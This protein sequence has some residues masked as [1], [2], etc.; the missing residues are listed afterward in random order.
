MQDTTGPALV[1]DRRRGSVAALRRLTVPL[2][3]LLWCV[4]SASYAPLL[5]RGGDAASLAIAG[6]LIAEGHADALYTQTPDMLAVDDPAWIAAAAPLGYDWRLYPYLYPPLV[7]AIAAPAS[8]LDFV[9]FKAGLLTLTLAALAGAILLSARAW[10]PRLLAPTPLLILLAAISASWPMT[11]QLIALNLQPLVLLAIVIAICAAQSDRPALAGAALALAGAVKLTPAV[12]VLYWLATRRFACAAWFLIASAALILLGLA[13]AGAPAHLAW[14]GRMQE[15][16]Q[17]IVPTAHNRSLAS[18]F[19]GLV[20]G[21]ETELQGLPI[22]PM[23]A[24]V[25]VALIIMTLAGAAF[26]LIGAQRSRRHSAAD[27]AGQT[28]LLLVAMLGTPL[29]WSHYFLVLAVAAMV[30]IGLVGVTSRT[31]AVLAGVAIVLSQ[32]VALAWAESAGP[33][34]E[35]LV[36]VLFLVLLL[37]ARRRYCQA[38]ATG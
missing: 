9:L 36:A 13:L 26:C 20:H 12:L 21:F 19:Y 16:A 5:W 31:M 15:L 10:A 28:A 7:A 1:A 24:W 34:L 37:D 29:A 14:I 30:W 22:S 8:G 3:L 11:T 4:L 23:P 2:I 18:L 6:R 33:G 38:P 25:K 27:A 35:P 17:A 32:P